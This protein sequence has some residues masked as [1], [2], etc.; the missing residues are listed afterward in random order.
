MKRLIAVPFFAIAFS[1]ASQADANPLFSYNNIAN[2]STTSNPSG[3]WSYQSALIGALPSTATNMVY[4]DVVGENSWETTFPTDSFCL[5]GPFG[6]MHPGN[7][8]DS[9]LGFIYPLNYAASVSVVVN[10]Q[11]DEKNSS[12][13]GKSLSLW[14]NNT[15]LLTRFLP[16]DYTGAI[17]DQT[18]LTMQPGDKLYLRLNRGSNNINFGDSQ[19]ES[20]TVTQ[21]SVP[22]PTALILFCL[23][24]VGLLATHGKRRRDLNLA[25]RET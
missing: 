17:V 1:C 6:L 4:P 22:E 23:G 12:S 15:L 14:L 18:S 13:D 25:G 16:G 21:T 20:I 2:F 19:F 24:G 9:L 10:S 3:P 11:D 5:I 7:Q 8:T